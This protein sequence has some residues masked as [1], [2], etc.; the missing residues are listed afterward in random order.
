MLSEAYF[1]HFADKVPERFKRMASSMG[2]TDFIQALVELQE[3]C[4]VRDLKMSDY[5]VTEGEL[6]DAARNARETMGFLYTLD[7]APLSDDDAE[8]ILR[9]SFRRISTAL[10][11]CG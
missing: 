7:P 2:G 6:P 4:G 8:G 5:G 9:A 3:A 10:P 11:F 1:R